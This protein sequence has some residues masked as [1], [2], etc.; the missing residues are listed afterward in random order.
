M[1]VG[2][3]GQWVFP[4]LPPQIK[5]GEHEIHKPCGKEDQKHGAHF[6]ELFKILVELLCKVPGFSSN[7]IFDNK[8]VYVLVQSSPVSFQ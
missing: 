1:T 7:H 8:C 2:Q 3:A 5:D 4:E 6:G